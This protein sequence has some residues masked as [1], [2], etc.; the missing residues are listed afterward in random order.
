MAIVSIMRDWGSSPSI[1]RITTT[2]TLAEVAITGYVD[3]QSAI[4]D[5]LNKGAFDWL[6]GD[7]ILI[8]ASDG[9]G[10]FQFTT[11][12]FA[13]FVALSSGG[14][15]GS[16]VLPTVANR[17]AHFTDTD[18]TI[19]SDA[20]DI[21]ND[22]D[23]AAGSSGIEGALASYPPT[24]ASGSLILQAVDNAGGDFI[25]AIKNPASTSQSNNYT[26]PTTFVPELKLMAGVVVAPFVDGN[27]IKAFGTDGIMLDS[28]IPV[29]SLANLYTTIDIF[30]N[31][32]VLAMGGTV[33]ALPAFF[34]TYRIRNIMINTSSGFT[35]GDRDVSLQ[36]VGAIPYTVVTAALLATPVNT[37]WGQTGLPYP[38]GTPCNRQSVF[39]QDVYLVYSGGTTDYDPDQLI[40]ITIS[41]TQ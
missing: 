17:I 10:F 7:L 21:S 37:L 16:V 4:I 40:S 22:G 15:G 6:V 2:N 38:V 41:F 11:N 30:I 39:N 36:D 25:C 20:A 1:V 23:I 28:G 35:G 18:G 24:P 12:D 33:L 31:T 9:D 8:T 34:G 14:G 13:T 19:S 26:L 29:T 5:D 32:N 3:T 27:L